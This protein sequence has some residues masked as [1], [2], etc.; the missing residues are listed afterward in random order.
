M[1]IPNCR[2]RWDALW[3]ET[4]ECDDR[5]S[6]TCSPKR[7]IAMRQL[8]LSAFCFSLNSMEIKQYLNQYAATLIA[9]NKWEN[10][11]NSTISTASSVSVR[12]WFTFP[13]FTFVIVC[14]AHRPTAHE[15]SSCQL[16]AIHMLRI[17]HE[18]ESKSCYFILDTSRLIRT[19]QRIFTLAPPTAS[20][21]WHF[22][23][24]QI[25]ATICVSVI[26]FAWRMPL[27]QWCT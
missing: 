17:N 25:N 14:I 5:L 15:V 2:H 16:A 6:A 3:T 12:G 10:I 13:L 21:Y 19:G 18:H 8:S 11:E 24:G 4:L 9:I 27:N 1:W 22:T 7:C 20:T 23:F 26:S